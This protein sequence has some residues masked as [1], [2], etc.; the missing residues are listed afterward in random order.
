[1]FTLP[2]LQEEDWN[3]LNRVLGVLVQASEA[4]AALLTDKAGFRLAEQGTEHSFDTTSLCALATGA[5]MATQAIAGLLD[6]PNFSNVYQQG[7]RF[8][9]LVSNVDDYSVLIVIF[10]SSVSAGAIKFHSAEVLP[11]IASQ[12]RRAKE[13]APGE[14]MDLAILNV[15]DT[16]SVFKKRL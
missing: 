7:E 1:M 4:T 10:P 12:L 3:E 13:R 15:A 14:G 5:F 6:E 9:M 2:Q 11:L 8:S 16:E